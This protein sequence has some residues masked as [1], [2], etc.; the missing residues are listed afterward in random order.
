MAGSFDFEA[1]VDEAAR[2]VEAEH[3]AHVTPEARAVL[4]TKANAHAA[5]VER[6]AHE[7]G[8]SRDQLVKAAVAQLREA[9]P[10]RRAALAPRLRNVRS[11]IEDGA[12]ARRDPAATFRIDARAVQAGMDRK[13]W[14]VPWC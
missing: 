12:S 10:P 6:V 9:L 13:C 5:E 7:Q 4:I 1:I 14:F 2:A 8:L 11:F 3:T